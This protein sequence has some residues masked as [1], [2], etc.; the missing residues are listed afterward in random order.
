MTKPILR[1]FRTTF[2]VVLGLVLLGFSVTKSPR[3]VW[4]A[5][6]SA[7]I[8]LYKVTDEYIVSRGDLIL[9]NP[10]TVVAR[11]AATRGYLPLGVPLVKRVAALSGDTV[12]TIGTRITVNGGTAAIRRN[13]DRLGRSLPVWRGCR[14]LGKT[15]VFLLMEGVP[16][17]FDGRYFG[18]IKLSQIL[19]R[20][21]PLWTR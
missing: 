13:T 10:P 20:L 1:P 11:F 17:S 9:I 8:G 18:P 6:A 19:G 12:C 21:V 15:D 7:P 4:N 5:S 3:L 14:S 2:P 16:D